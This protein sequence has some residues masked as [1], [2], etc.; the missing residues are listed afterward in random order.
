MTAMMMEV[1]MAAEMMIDE[2]APASCGN[3]DDQT[4]HV[5]FICLHSSASSGFA[6]AI[7]KRP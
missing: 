4:I 7:T 5:P 1:M 2:C 6:T 3:L